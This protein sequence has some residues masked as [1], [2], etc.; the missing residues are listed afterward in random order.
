VLLRGN[1]FE[2]VRNELTDERALRRA[3]EERLR[4]YVNRPDPVVIWDF[5]ATNGGGIADMSGNGFRTT[6]Y[7]GA[8]VIPDSGH[9][10]SARFD[11]TGWL[12]LDEPAV[13][14]APD[15][16]V[17]LWIKPAT[18]H[19]R[20]GLV[21]KRFTG[22]EAPFILTQN[23]AA[24]GFEATDTEHGWSFNFVS[25]AVLKEG[26]WTHVAAVAQGDKG[27]ALYA[28]GKVIAEKRNPAARVFTD[29]P[30]IV[31]REAWGGEPPKGDTPGYF[32]G[33]MSEV[34]IW[35]RALTA[36]EIQSEFVRQ[37]SRK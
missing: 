3:A 7:G 37:P 10:P 17:S 21:S 8:T 34:R 35:S 18:I 9:G 16:T 25:P 27:V 5:R 2:N 32:I 19:G 12:R 1:T 6:I 36:E 15:M 14:N 31:G 4:R 24:I 28:N 11:G 22:S 30:L 13:F 26:E 33:Q 23:N 20:R 29:E